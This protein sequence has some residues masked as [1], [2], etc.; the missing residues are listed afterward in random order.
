MEETPLGHLDADHRALAVQTHKAIHKVIG[1]QKPVHYFQHHQTY[2]SQK[3]LV[4]SEQQNGRAPY[5][6]HTLRCLGFRETSDGQELIPGQHTRQVLY[7]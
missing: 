3:M 4:F 7:H 6:L 2:S 1:T 5:I